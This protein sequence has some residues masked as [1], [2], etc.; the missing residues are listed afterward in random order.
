MVRCGCFRANKRCGSLC[1]CFGSCAND[2][3]I[4][5]EPV[6]GPAVFGSGQSSVESVQSG[7]YPPADL[8]HHMHL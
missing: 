5:P 6:V 4:K 2:A 3:L 7:N 8:G 1:K